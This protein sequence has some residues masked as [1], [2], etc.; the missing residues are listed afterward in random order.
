MSPGRISS[1][2]RKSNGQEETKP[3]S[4]DTQARRLFSQGKTP[5]EVAN[6]LDLSVEE[7]ERIQRDFWK[8][9]G[10]Y[11]IYA[12]YEEVIKRDIP[13]F[14]T[15]YRIIKETGMDEKDISKTLQYSEQ[16]LFLDELVQSRVNTVK[17]SVEKNRYLIAKDK[18]LQNETER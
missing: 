1:I 8:L 4:V 9:K 12:A 13:S 17:S 18:E 14:L 6:E 15:F 7:T 10:L 2:L 16:M 11:D 5:L 3:V